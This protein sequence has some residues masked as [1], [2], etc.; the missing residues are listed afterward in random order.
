M[1]YAVDHFII[2][3]DDNVVKRWW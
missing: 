2:V 1:E 3:P